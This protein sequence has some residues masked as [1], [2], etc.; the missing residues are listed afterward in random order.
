MRMTAVEKYFVNRHSHTERV[1]NHAKDLLRRVHD[2]RPGM[3]YLDVG[4]GVGDAARKIAESGALDVTGI[5]VD[6]DQIQAANRGPALPNL[7]FRAMD[8]THLQFGD[9]QFDVVATSKTRHHIPN[10]E[11]AFEEMARVLHAGGY[12]I[13]TDFTA[14]S[15]LAPAARRLFPSAGFPSEEALNLLS[16]KAGLTRVYRART[17]VV[18]EPDLAQRSCEC[19]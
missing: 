15:W 6:P 7:H 13:Y 19:S 17:F 11:R 8:A 4:C 10:W 18:V 12:L 5:D 9:G 1:A 2:V 14:P 3:S 16:A